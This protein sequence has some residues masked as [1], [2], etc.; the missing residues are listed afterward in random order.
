MNRS[1]RV[2]DA[3]AF[4][5]CIYSH[6]LR[7]SL[8]LLYRHI[9][10]LCGGARLRGFCYVLWGHVIGILLHL[11]NRIFLQAAQQ[12]L[13]FGSI[14]VGRVS[15]QACWF[16]YPSSRVASGGTPSPS[17]SVRYSYGGFNFAC[18]RHEYGGPTRSVAARMNGG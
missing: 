11:F 6:F 4:I 15:P 13:G 2:K 3:S 18:I 1:G 10:R 5:L 16:L 8:S 9:G 14:A 17:F 7:V 12:I